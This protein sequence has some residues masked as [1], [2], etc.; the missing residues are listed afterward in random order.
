MLPI[1]STEIFQFLRST[2]R[3][4][5]ADP[6]DAQLLDCFVSRGDS[7]ALEALVRRHAA[8]VW[9]VCRP[10]LGNHHDAEDA[11]QATFLVLVRRAASVHPQSR[12]GNWLHGVA[13]QT[14]LKARSLKAKRQQRERSLPEMPDSETTQH[15]IWNDLQP[16]LDREICRLPEKYRAV[17][18]WCEL[19]GKTLREAARQLG[20]PEGTVASRLARAR[21]M[22]AKRLRRHG[23][24]M[25]GGVLTG[26]FSQR[27]SARV[28][29]SV[30]SST[31]EVATRVATGLATTEVTSVKIAA[32]TEGVVKSMLLNKLKL[33]TATLMMILAL[34]VVGGLGVTTLPAWGQ[35]KK[36]GDESKRLYTAP[37]KD[38]RQNTKQGRIYFLQQNGTEGEKSL[39]AVGADGKGGVTLTKNLDLQF[40]AV[41]PDGTQVVYGGAEIIENECKIEL[42]LKAVDDDKPGE[43]LKEQAFGYWCWSPDG[44]SLAFTNLRKFMN[45]ENF[46]VLSH[47][48]LDL[49]TK[50][51]TPLQLPGDG[52]P[53]TDTKLEGH[54]IITDWSKD[55]KWLL[56]TYRTAGGRGDLYR[57]KSDGSETERIGEGAWGK[58]SPDGK[59]VLYLSD[60]DD[61]SPEK[62]KLFIVD[63]EGGKPQQVSQEKNGEFLGHCWSPDGK[64]IAYV[65]RQ[66]RDA[67]SQERETFLMVMD[68]DGKNSNVIL[69]KKQTGKDNYDPFS[70]PDWRP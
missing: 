3:S 64:K 68:A 20:C 38:D 33:G 36:E 67:K 43:S 5:E 32:L 21:A 46:L 50:K 53:A 61:D 65:W 56:T 4:A 31:I 27:A 17:I 57:V 26:V 39:V 16:L 9:G 55:G 37:I 60:K 34:I 12:V 22:L 47:S 14:A 54:A 66:D 29:P 62:A 7:G 13:R 42:F 28:P 35:S 8:M 18:V 10:L 63:V 58:L 69:S 51:T 45:L 25:M 11:F 15:D 41:S 59:K 52:V 6:T 2:V 49:K 19:E 23:L 30:V 40:F 48:I 1:P 44:R 24:A 70:Y